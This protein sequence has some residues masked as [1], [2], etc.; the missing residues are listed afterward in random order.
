MKQATKTS[1]LF[2]PGVKASPS[3]GIDIT[4]AGQTIHVPDC[5]CEDFAD[6]FESARV[7][8]TPNKN[9]RRSG[10]WCRETGENPDLSQGD[11]T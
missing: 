4:Q 3:G 6:R 9:P 1:Q 10:G 5:E 8:M 7:H 2:A 11:L